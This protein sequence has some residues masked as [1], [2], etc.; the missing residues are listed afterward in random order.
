MLARSFHAIYVWKSINKVAEI[1]RSMK[2]N[3]KQEDILKLTGHSTNVSNNL[4]AHFKMEICI[5]SIKGSER[6]GARGVNID[7]NIKWAE[8][9]A[10]IH[11]KGRR[12][13]LRV[14][15]LRSH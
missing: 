4:I 7:V 6:R 11:Y 3:V 1:K 13:L 12:T 15:D 14:I 10:A 9:G 2:N 8:G 5:E